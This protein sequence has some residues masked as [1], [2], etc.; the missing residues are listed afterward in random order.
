[1]RRSQA[2]APDEA[3]RVSDLH[4]LRAFVLAADLRSVTAAAH[5]TG[6]SKATI[7]RRITRLEAALGVALVQRSSRGIAATEDGVAYRQR[8]GALFEQLNEANSAAMHG[9]KA[10]PSGQLRVSL[11]PGLAEVLAPHLTS[12]GLAYPRVALVVE[13]SSRFVD[14]EAEHFDVAVR[15]TAQLPDSSLVAIRVGD[16]K[17]EGL[18]VASPRY[19]AGRPPPRHPSDLAAHRMLLI[20]DTAAPSR[21]PFVHRTT[22]KSAAVVLPVAVAGSELGLLRQLAVAGAGITILPDLGV[23]TELADGR[24][25][26]VLR[27]YV[28]PSTAVFLVHRGGAFVPPKIRAFLD[29][30]REALP[31]R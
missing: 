19:L 10:V 20:G 21:V 23:A 27:S 17:S 22:R 29:H 16:P 12:F 24:L 11:P 1:M 26:H 28:W 15:A 2:R 18:C 4:D 25:V 31:L 14:L 13:L 7:S 6:E 30:L 3:M 8:I 5:V 9:G